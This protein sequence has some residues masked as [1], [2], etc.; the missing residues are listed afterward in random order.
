[1][2]LWW[3]VKIEMKKIINRRNEN[4]TNSFD[5]HWWRNHGWVCSRHRLVFRGHWNRNKLKS[6]DNLG[7]PTT[8]W[9][10]RKRSLN[11]FPRVLM[12]IF[13]FPFKKSS[14]DLFVFHLNSIE[15]QNFFFWFSSFL[16]SD[17][18][19]SFF[20]LKT[21]RRRN[22]L[23]KWVCSSTNPNWNF[24]EAII[25]PFLMTSFGH[26]LP[27]DCVEDKNQQFPCLH[28]L[29]HDHSD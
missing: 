10:R 3:S 22:F 29:N 19:R 18:F 6:H 28:L 4:L 7:V 21:V 27:G 16:T 20:F 2:H 11:F 5:F 15:K 13:F 12:K 8:S 24:I 26:R 25:N 9:L 23:S 17:L 1:M 14:S